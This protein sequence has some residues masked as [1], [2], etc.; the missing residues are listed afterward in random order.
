VRTRRAP[1]FVTSPRA[2]R[3]AA[4]SRLLRLRGLVT[5]P[6]TSGSFLAGIA[7]AGSAVLALLIAPLIEGL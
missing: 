1:A 7:L 4:G 3:A 2:G 5:P 6:A